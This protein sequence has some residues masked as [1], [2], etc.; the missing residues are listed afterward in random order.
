[1]RSM[2][3]PVEGRAAGKGG[4]GADAFAVRGNQH[5][6]LPEEASG[7]PHLP[8]RGAA[9]CAAAVRDDSAW[10]ESAGDRTKRA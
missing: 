2:D 1:M 4:Y 5:G 6:I 9:V 7:H 3:V 8:R 10:Q